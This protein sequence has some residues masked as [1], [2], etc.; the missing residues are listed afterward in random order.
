[1]EMKSYYLRCCIALAGAIA[2]LH[3]P[4]HAEQGGLKQLVFAPNAAQEKEVATGRERQ[5]QAD[6]VKRLESLV[7]EKNRA[8]DTAIIQIKKLQAK[9]PALAENPVI[10]VAYEQKGWEPVVIKEIGEVSIKASTGVSIVRVPPIAAGI[11]MA[12]LASRALAHFPCSNMTC[13]VVPK[14]LLSQDFA[15]SEVAK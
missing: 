10:D 5:R 7:A 15:S 11:G 13:F 12:M 2:L 8:L 3:T 1:M 14:S 6:E 9:H 4:A